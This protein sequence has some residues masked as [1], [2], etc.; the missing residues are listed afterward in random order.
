MV[1][2][3][4][5]VLVTGLVVVGL[6]AHSLG[7]LAAGADYIAD[8]AAIGVSLLAIRLSTRPPTP[9]RPH[10]YPKATAL[11]ASINGGWLL[12]LSLLVIAGALDRLATGAPH[13]D[14]LPVLIVSGVASIVMV[15]GVVILGGDVDADDD[16]GGDLNTRAVLLDT[17]ADAAAAAGVAITGGVILATGGFYWLDPTAAL[18]IAIVVGYHAVVLLKDVVRT[19]RRQP[20]RQR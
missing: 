13:V 9:R 17:A 7:V 8:A 20:Q 18:V 19:L 1:L 2:A 6:T 14:G 15:V 5:V 12:I 16:V 10:G 4:N 11:A 3:L